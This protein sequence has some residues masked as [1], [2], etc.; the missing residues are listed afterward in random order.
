MKIINYTHARNHLRKVIDDVVQDDEPAIIIS[1]HNQVVVISR[2][3]Y[4]SLVKVKKVA[5]GKII[6][7]SKSLVESAVGREVSVG[8]HHKFT[9]K[10]NNGDSVNATAKIINI[11]D[12]VVEFEVVE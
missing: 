8:E 10:R 5:T 1:K 7:Q 4:E 2:E 9:E 11:V 12:D 3:K 6:K